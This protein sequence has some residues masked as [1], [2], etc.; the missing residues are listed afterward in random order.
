[1]I[2]I[3]LQFY[4]SLGTSGPKFASLLFEGKSPKVHLSL[5]CCICIDEHLFTGEIVVGSTVSLMLLLITV[6]NVNQEAL[7][8]I[9]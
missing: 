7:Q 2:T 8:T 4:N 3:F 1:M 5:V 6:I 9:G